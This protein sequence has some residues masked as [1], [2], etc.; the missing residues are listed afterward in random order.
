MLACLLDG[1]PRSL[2]DLRSE[3]CL[4]LQLAASRGTDE[5]GERR[6]G[7]PTPSYASVQGTRPL[8][9]WP[10]ARLSL[11]RE[12][13]IAGKHYASSALGK[14]RQGPPPPSIKFS[15]RACLLAW[16]RGPCPLPPQRTEPKEPHPTRRVEAIPKTA[17]A[18]QTSSFSCQGPLAACGKGT[19]RLPG[20]RGRCRRRW[21]DRLAGLARL[22]FRVQGRAL[23]W[24]TGHERP[25][26]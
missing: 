17:Q 21:S 9:A 11:E 3:A 22:V 10:P 23:S 26:R 13:P 7:R 18:R 12:T 25:G 15:L 16:G 14:A 8:M 20:P 4:C 1:W 6:R 5:A 2:K 19:T 24:S